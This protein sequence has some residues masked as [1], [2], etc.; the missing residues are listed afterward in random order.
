[1]KRIIRSR[2]TLAS[3]SFVLGASCL[4]IYQKYLAPNQKQDEL[5]R[6]RGIDPIFDQFYN[7]SFFS[8]SLDPFENMRRMRE[9][10]EKQIKTPGEGG[11]IF[12]SWFE[13][14]F[15]AGSADEISERED[16]NFIYYDVKINGLNQEKLTVNVGNGYI[17][18]SG[19]VEEK[20]NANN[21]TKYFRSTFNRSF[22]VP[23]SVDAIKFQM[24]QEKDKI[25]IKFP[26]IK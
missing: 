19:E 4:F 26:K 21:E 1:M 22:P 3:I 10:M 15:G 7:D 13:K 14:K 6:L 20:N 8:K 11:A 17:N 5:S 2:I 16:E 23:A 24:E 18:I 9:Q 25:I 12:D